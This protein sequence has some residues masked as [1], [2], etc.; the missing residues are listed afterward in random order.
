[1]GRIHIWAIYMSIVQTT[2]YLSC[3]SLYYCPPFRPYR[4]NRRVKRTVG[5]EENR[6]TNVRGN[7]NVERRQPS[8]SNSAIA[9]YQF[10][11]RIYTPFDNLL[12][13]NIYTN[14]LNRLVDI[15]C[16]RLLLNLRAGQSRR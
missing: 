4:N 16:Y 12:L 9:L 6:G 11:C 7:I 5:G 2:K 13:I 1:M 10:I 14:H 3:N 15:S 8:R